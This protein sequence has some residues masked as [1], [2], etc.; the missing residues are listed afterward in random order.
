MKFIT[1]KAVRYGSPGQAPTR[2]QGEALMKLLE[3]VEGW[4]VDGGLHIPNQPVA[5][6]GDWILMSAVN[7]ITVMSDEAFNAHYKALK[8]A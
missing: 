6:W 5:H 3:N 1:V 8:G 7:Y 4:Y 2:E